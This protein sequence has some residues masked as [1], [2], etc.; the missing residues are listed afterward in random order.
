MKKKKVEANFILYLAQLEINDDK[1]STTDTSNTEGKSG[2]WFWNESANKSDSDFKRE[3]EEQEEGEEEDED[4]ESNPETEKPRTERAVS[5]EIEIKWN[6]EEENK[7]R[8]VYRN[9]S[10]STAKRVQ[11]AVLELEKQTSKNIILGNYDNK[12]LT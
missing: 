1:L 9:G 8:R 2:T 11:N 10:I 5:L 4:N 6:K 3:G 7:L 12:I